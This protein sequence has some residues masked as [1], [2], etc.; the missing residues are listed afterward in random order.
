M[1]LVVDGVDGEAAVAAA[2]IREAGGDKMSRTFT[3][4]LRKR[5]MASSLLRSKIAER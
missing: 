2:P 3:E 4:K 5:L 1:L